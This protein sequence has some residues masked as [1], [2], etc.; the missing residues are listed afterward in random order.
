[1]P[2]TEDCVHVIW[3]TQ[4]QHTLVVS[5]CL[6][7]YVCMRLER[8]VHVLVVFPSHLR[9]LPLLTFLLLS[10]HVHVSFFLN[11]Y[12]SLSLSVFWAIPLYYSSPTTSWVSSYM[13]IHH[14][15][16]VFVKETSQGKA[17]LPKNNKQGSNPQ[18]TACCVDAVLPAV[19]MY[20]Y[21]FLLPLCPLPPLL[22]P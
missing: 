18:H 7:M 16:Y 15:L 4:P 21:F 19:C 10:L 1:M 22:P 2:R 11:T 17:T 3:H 8:N 12:V 14:V 9:T 20:I 6:Y 5:H 13:Y